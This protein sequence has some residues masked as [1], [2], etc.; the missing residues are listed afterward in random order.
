[1]VSKSRRFNDRVYYTG[2]AATDYRQAGGLL[3]DKKAFSRAPVSAA[4]Q[5]KV[6]V[7]TGAEFCLSSLLRTKCVWHT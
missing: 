4:F 3:E 7:K 5:D 1:M 6:C 2:P